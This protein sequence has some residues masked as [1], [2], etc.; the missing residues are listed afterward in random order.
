VLVLGTEGV[1]GGLNCVKNLVVVTGNRRQRV[2]RV[3]RGGRVRVNSRACLATSSSSRVAVGD[4]YR[5][6]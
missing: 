1:L 5:L 2:C 3:R 6:G 4:G